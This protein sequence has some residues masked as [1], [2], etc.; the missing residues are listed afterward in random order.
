[1]NTIVLNDATAAL[2]ISQLLKQIEN[3]AIELRDAAGNPVALVLSPSDRDAWAYAEANLDLDRHTEE[4]R[5]AL[6]RRSGVTTEELLR[7]AA[8]SVGTEQ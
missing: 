6:A 3:G 1:M 2:P 7:K 8:S 4:V 5:L